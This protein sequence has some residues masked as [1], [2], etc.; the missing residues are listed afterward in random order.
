MSARAYGLNSVFLRR[1]ENVTEVNSYYS[2]QAFRVAPTPEPEPQQ[3]AW[4]AWFRGLL[5]CIFSRH[6][7]GEEAA[8]NEEPVRLLDMHRLNAEDAQERLIPGSRIPGSGFSPSTG[9]Q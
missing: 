3:R 2:A 9:S 4:A 5:S 6:L 8:S 7:E 1:L